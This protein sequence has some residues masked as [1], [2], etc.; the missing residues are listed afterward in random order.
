MYVIYRIN[1]CIYIKFFAEIISIIK[2]MK[3]KTILY[4]L[5]LFI[6]N[7][8]LL[9]AQSSER[10][11]GMLYELSKQNNKQFQGIHFL[12]QG[13]TAKIRKLIT[14]AGGIFKY[15]SGDIASV[16]APS[17]SLKNILNSLDFV[18]ADIPDTTLV[19][20]N[21]SMIVN[22]GISQVHEGLAP[23]EKGY[24]GEGVVIGIIDTGLDITHPDFKDENGKTRIKYL[25]DRSKSGTHHPDGFY[26]GEEWTGAQIDSNVCDHIAQL[27]GTHVTGIASG[28][29]R[30]L[31]KYKG[32]APKSDIIFVT[33]GGIWM[34]FAPHNPTVD[35]VA[36]IFK[37]AKEMGKPCVI[38][39]SFGNPFAN[40]S[41]RDL[42][43]R[44]IDNLILE[45][46][47]RAMTCGAG[48]SGNVKAHVGY[49]L[50]KDT[51]FTWYRAKINSQI[52]FMISTDS[53]SSNK[54]SIAFSAD[55][56]EGSYFN[57][58]KT[59]FAKLEDINISFNCTTDLGHRLGS[60]NF[61]PQINKYGD[62]VDYN[63]L[64]VPD[65]LNYLYRL[66]LTGSGRIDL[67]HYYNYPETGLVS[68]DLPDSAEF[69]DIVHY[70]T[71]DNEQTI[72][73][74]FA[75][76]KEVITVGNSVN[77]TCYSDVNGNFH[78]D[79]IPYTLYS[80]SSRGPTN[81]GRIKPE[82]VAAGTR[83]ISC[84]VLSAMPYFIN[85]EPQKVAP[86]GMHLL[87]GGT[88]AASPVVAGII[89]LYLQ[90]YPEAT[91]K[92][93]REFL[94]QCT[95]PVPGFD[96][97]GNEVGYGKINAFKFLTQCQ[98]PPS[99]DEKESLLPFIAIYPN[100]SSD[101]VTIF[102]PN[103]EV[104]DIKIYNIL[105]SLVNSTHFRN[106]ATSYTLSM[107]KFAEGIYNVVFYKNDNTILS[108]KI[109]VQP[110]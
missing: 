110:D 45:Q 76:S 63:F 25:W 40:H 108:R 64:L 69:P 99:I 13:D 10:V 52:L 16:Y 35:A 11:G 5:G 56:K 71:P 14:N 70:L 109:I 28:N 41:G 80:N 93:I 4:L 97:P 32:V 65:S 73:G 47:G 59:S 86:G 19:L 58:G 17:M 75:C 24:D 62:K 89:A 33:L 101:K 74:G 29:G 34:G 105:G 104:S 96:I 43:A 21:D 57:L 78:Q 39:A 106:A 51:V 42:E 53:A 7:T 88:S 46:N 61:P 23:L 12:M 6:I 3:S 15:S 84:G 100:P 102:S 2:E 31:N 38:N 98:K 66:I 60:I 79:A 107:N 48:N 18:Y 72:M 103:A 81:D 30:A 49:N 67:Y 36:Y 90:E 85:N 26:Y 50:K 20:L 92:E 55:K 37:K 77:R 82:I 27:H 1:F 54:I 95:D 68:S 44:L 8:Q 83:T 9:S 91:N 22:N 94:I 87:G